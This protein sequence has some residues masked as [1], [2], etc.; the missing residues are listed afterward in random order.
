[1][2]PRAVVRLQQLLVVVV[3]VLLAGAMVALGRWQLQVYD[4]QGARV[5]AERAAAPPLPLSAAAPVGTAVT[6]GFG[7]S[8]TFAGS[9]DPEL[10]LLV[11]LA[12]EPGRYRVLTALRQGDGSLVPVVRGVVDSPAA[13]APP[14]E[15]VTQVGVL[16]P[17]EEAP[18]R[19]ARPGQIGSVRVPALAQ[20][21]SGRLV[22]GY[23]ILAAP[24]ADAQGL[25]PAPLVLPDAPGR[26]RNAAYAVQWWLFA[27]F[28]LVMAVR[29]ARDLGRPEPEPVLEITAGSGSDP[30]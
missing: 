27:A 18:D 23:V 12:D 2:R 16:L 8:V 29:I 21:W 13:P 7:R 14:R 11:P 19:G 20:Q 5:S 26:F 17:S 22:G 28:A 15:P 24:E 9:Y 3:A 1:V 25:V 10:Q 4:E 30:A 6:E